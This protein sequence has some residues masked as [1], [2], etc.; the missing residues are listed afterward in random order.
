MARLIF[1]KTNVQQLAMANREG[2]VP[3]LRPQEAINHLND[4]RDVVGMIGR[5]AIGWRAPAGTEIV[6]SDLCEWDWAHPEVCQ[7]R[8]RVQSSESQGSR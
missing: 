5:L 3:V 6:F 8:L 2:A 4:G 1:V 7:A